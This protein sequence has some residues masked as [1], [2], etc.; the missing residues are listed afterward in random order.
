MLLCLLSPPRVNQCTLCS[1]SPRILIG[2]L[3]WP[4]SCPKLKSTNWGFG[5]LI[6]TPLSSNALLQVAKYSVMSVSSSPHSTMPSIRIRNMYGL[7]AEPWCSPT[8]TSKL[9]LSPAAIGPWDK[10]EM[11][12]P[13]TMATITEQPHVKRVMRPEPT[14]SPQSTVGQCVYKTML[15]NTNFV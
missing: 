11:E 13:D 6:F 10:I 15:D 9:W 2:P 4:L 12:L 7:K 1:S 3:H 14:V 5:L 8:S